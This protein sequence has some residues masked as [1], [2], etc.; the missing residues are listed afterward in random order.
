MKHEDMT[1]KIDIENQ[2]VSHM[3]KLSQHFSQIM[4]DT[5]KRNCE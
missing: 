4:S 1:F 2:N 3:T 5:L